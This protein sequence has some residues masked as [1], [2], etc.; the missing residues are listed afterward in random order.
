MHIYKYMIYI[1]Y[2]HFISVHTH[3]PRKYITLGVLL[4]M[5]FWNLHF[6]L[7]M[8]W[9]ARRQYS[10]R[11]KSL[12]SAIWLLGV[13]SWFY[14]CENLVKLLQFYS[15]WCFLYS[16]GKNSTCKHRCVVRIKWENICKIL[17]T[18]DIQINK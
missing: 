1:I 12:A 5:L 10:T 8:S 15:S 4:Y 17:S 6:S 9:L 11:V 16:D 3:T 13:E 2:I 18:P 7:N 14:Y